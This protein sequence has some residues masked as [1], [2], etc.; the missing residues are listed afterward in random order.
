MSTPDNPSSPW[1]AAAWIGLT[2]S[3]ADQS[4][5]VDTS[6]APLNN[7][8]W[9]PNEPNYRDGTETCTNLLTYC[10][11]GS[12]LVNDYDCSRPLRVLCAIPAGDGCSE[13]PSPMLFCR[14]ALLSW[15]LA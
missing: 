9:C 1:S 7:V 14:T 6:G 3:T 5:W 4:L 8:P 13:L 11:G 2:R 12:A 15:P 10:G